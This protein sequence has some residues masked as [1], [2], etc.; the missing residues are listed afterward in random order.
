MLV[1]AIIHRHNCKTVVKLPH[2]DSLICISA[3]WC[4]QSY[5]QLFYVLHLLYSLSCFLV[6]VT[7]LFHV[8]MHTFVFCSNHLLCNHLSVLH[9]R[10]TQMLCVCCSHIICVHVACFIYS[11]MFTSKGRV[12]LWATRH[13]VHWWLYTYQLQTLFFRSTY[14]CAGITSTGNTCLHLYSSLLGFSYN[15]LVPTLGLR[16]NIIRHATT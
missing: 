12:D 7:F 14:L 6:L 16:Q 2:L 15:H 5:S 9:Q 3:F 10:H 1:C 11:Y 13:K 8:P 4:I